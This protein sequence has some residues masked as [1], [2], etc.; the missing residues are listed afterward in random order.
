[1]IAMIIAAMT[2]S[3]PDGIGTV[4]RTTAIA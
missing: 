4:G 3:E 2:P 1:M